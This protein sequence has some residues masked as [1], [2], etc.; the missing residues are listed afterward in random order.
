VRYSHLFLSTDPADQAKLPEALD[1][2]HRYIADLV[3]AKAAAPADDLLSELITARDEGD[4]LDDAELHSMALLLLMSGFET[5]ASFIPNA[6]LALLDHPDRLAALRADPDLVPTAVEELLRYAST[7]AS[8][9]RY[10]TE[11]VT[12]GGVTIRRGEA[13]VVSWAAANRDPRRFPDPDTLDL[14]RTDNRHI[15]FAHGIHHCLGAPLARLE[16]QIAIGSLL[17]R[18]PTIRLA[19]PRTDLAYRITPNVRAVTSFPV[20]CSN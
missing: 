5:T 18:C 20:V 9:A 13:V 11:D 2:M 19:V 4:R 12:L 10:A 17:A 3:A 7:S 14:H 1:F 15:A 8:L 6:L 16:S